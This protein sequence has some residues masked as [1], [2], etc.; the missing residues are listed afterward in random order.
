M[1]PLPPPPPPP[2]H[3]VTSKPLT[4]LL[5]ITFREQVPENVYAVGFDGTLNKRCPFERINR[6]PSIVNPSSG[7]LER[8]V[9]NI[10]D[11]LHDRSMPY[12]KILRHTY[13]TT[14]CEI[15]AEVGEVCVASF[16]WK[17]SGVCKSVERMWMVHAMCGEG[18][19]AVWDANFCTKHENKTT[20]IMRKGKLR[21]D[22][23]F[24]VEHYVGV[25]NKIM[26]TFGRFFPTSDK[27]SPKVET[28]P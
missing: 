14:I 11:M 24:M 25:L 18:D 4:E 19:Q 23:P 6:R 16:D 17:C 22:V 8:K 2:P 9:T 3:H 12:Q 21:E 1:L 10:F 26:G 27:H 20:R 7:N 5:D 28:I 15:K 13:L